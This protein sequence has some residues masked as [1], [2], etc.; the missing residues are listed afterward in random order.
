MKRRIET[1][2]P[3]RMYHFFLA[4]IR[5]IIMDSTDW[6][7]PMKKHLFIL[8]ILTVLMLF[9]ACNPAEEVEP[10]SELGE[11]DD[12]I[13]YSR[14]KIG[15][16]LSGTGAFYDQFKEDILKACDPLDYEAD[17]VIADSGAKQQ[18]DIDAMVA[19]GA[20]VI[21]IDPVDVDVLE[22]VLA[23]CEIAEVPVVNI[24]D[25]ING[26]V[27]TL[28]T[29]DYSVIGEKAGQRAIS[30]FDDGGGLCLELKSDYDSF[31]MQLKSDGFE[32]SLSGNKN[33]TVAADAFCGDD[34]EKAY[35]AAKEQIAQNG[36]NFIF[37]HNAALARGALRA[38]EESGKTV[39][40]VMCGGEMDML[41]SVQ[42]GKMD[43][44][45]FFGPK[46]LADIVVGVADGF[47]KS[48]AYEPGL[49]MELKVDVATAENVAE[50]LSADL[51][52]AQVKPE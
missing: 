27:S 23:D 29:P 30:A 39:R 48:T 41:Q 49:Y 46:E 32:Q 26:I 22:S 8:M 51:Q 44:A 31:I 37:A 36:I 35:Q 4:R 11:E 19:A 43:A 40:L 18:R 45:I 13:G 12:D 2:I 9:G 14:V 24:I 42:S 5:G 3:D 10:P 16:S 33:V 6:E 52:Y 17:I 15:L 1:S 38:I 47:I 28:I 20:S 34:E 21:V 25:S 50:Y 7:V